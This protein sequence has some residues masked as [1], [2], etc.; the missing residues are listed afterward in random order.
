[1]QNGNV[2]PNVE[3]MPNLEQIEAL[4]DH[5][6][7][8][9]YF[10]PDEAY[11]PSSVLGVAI[12]VGFGLAGSG[13]QVGFRVGS[14]IATPNQYR[15]FFENG[16]LLFRKGKDTGMSIDSDESILPQGE[17]NDGQFW[18]DLPD[19]DDTVKNGI[20]VKNVTF[21]IEF[22]NLNIEMNR[23]GEHVG[24]WEHYTLRVSNFDGELW[25]IY[26]SEHNS[27]EWVDASNVEFIEG[28][29]PIDYSSI[30]MV[31]QVSQKAEHIFKSHQS[32]GSGSRTTSIKIGCNICVSPTVLYDGRSDLEQIISHLP[33]F[34]RLMVE[35][36]IDLFPIELYG[37]KGPPVGLKRRIIG[38]VMKDVKF[39]FLMHGES[40][41]VICIVFAN[42]SGKIVV[43]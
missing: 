36:L 42:I 3:A 40:G 15:G 24:D 28:N 43:K 10:H 5:Y 11:L 31:T 32:L 38:R 4:N 26:F 25:S 22:L 13:W 14:E 16:A 12:Q 20:I 33:F 17:K 7:P 30:N 21:T 29:K 34:I 1:M 8:T 19:E 2:N 18:M 9:V 23:V 39:Y 27:G 41:C 37:E 35:T 6:G